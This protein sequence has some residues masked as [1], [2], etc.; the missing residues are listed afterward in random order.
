M[1]G[2]DTSFLVA[3]ELSTHPLHAHA[4]RLASDYAA[5]RFAVAPQVTAEFVHVVTDPRRFEKPLSMSDALDRSGKWWAAVDTMLAATY[6]TKGISVIV[7]SNWRDFAVFPGIH[8][9]VLG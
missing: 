6:R 2:V 8:P 3:F 4:R 9:V 7:S 1:I 5:E